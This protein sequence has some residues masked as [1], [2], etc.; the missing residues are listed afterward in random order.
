MFFPIALQTTNPGRALLTVPWSSHINR[1][2]RKSLTD[3]PAGQSDRYFFLLN[4]NSIL[5]S[6]MILACIQLTKTPTTAAAKAKSCSTSYTVFSPYLPSPAESPWRPEL[7]FPS[8]WGC[9]KEIW[10]KCN[11]TSFCSRPVY[12]AVWWVLFLPACASD[13][14]PQHPTPYPSPHP[15]QCDTA[16]PLAWPSFQLCFYLPL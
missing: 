8:Y 4:G 2:S 13:L 11:S 10:T 12:S 1:H 9:K 7:D 14:L 5:S 3:L 6:Q 16:Q 15:L